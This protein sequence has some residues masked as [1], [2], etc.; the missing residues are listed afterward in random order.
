MAR[1][2]DMSY[3]RK[4]EKNEGLNGEENE[5]EID[6]IEALRAALES[7]PEDKDDEMFSDIETSDFSMEDWFA[8]FLGDE[9]TEIVAP[10]LEAE[11][12]EEQ[13][14]ESRFSGWYDEIDMIPDGVQLMNDIVGEV[15]KYSVKD[16][17]EQIQEEDR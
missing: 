9:E 14:W 12:S 7:V 3:I 11:Q 16:T 1:S 13:L 8:S 2:F 4:Q 10:Q 15:K 6:D 17:Q 5:E